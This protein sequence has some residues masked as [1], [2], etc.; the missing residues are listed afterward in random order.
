MDVLTFIGRLVQSILPKG[1]HR[2]RYYGIHATCVFKKMKKQLEWM[3][4]E[5]KVRIEGAYQVVRKSF[6]ERVIETF[7]RDPFKCIKCGG[8]MALVSIWHPG[9]GEIMVKRR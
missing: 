6:R 7:G 3:V 1:F 9:Y 2:I 4:G 8:L 5:I